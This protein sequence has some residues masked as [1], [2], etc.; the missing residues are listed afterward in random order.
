MHPYIY[1][2]QKDQTSRQSRQAA[3][4]PSRQADALQIEMVNHLGSWPLVT[5]FPPFCLPFLAKGFIFLVAVPA[6]CSRRMPPSAAAAAAAVVFRPAAV[7]AAWRKRLV[8]N[9]KIIHEILALLS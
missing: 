9:L 1:L 7:V 2:V 8:G 6:P 5:V 4:S 3:Y